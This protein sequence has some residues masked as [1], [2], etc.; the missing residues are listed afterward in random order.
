MQKLLINDNYYDKKS[1]EEIENFIKVS[2]DYQELNEGITA[3]VK[4]NKKFKL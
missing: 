2:I 1:F 4:N 3:E